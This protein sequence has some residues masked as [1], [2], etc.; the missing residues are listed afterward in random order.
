MKR[1]MMKC[2]GVA[3]CALAMGCS[4]AATASDGTTGDA[5][6][7]AEEASTACGAADW[8]DV[9]AV[10]VQS[11][12]SCH[13]PKPAAGAPMSLVTPADLKAA[14]L[15]MRGIDEAHYSVKRMAAGS[16]PP[17]G[18]AAGKV[19]AIQKWIDDG[20]PDPASCDAGK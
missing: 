19:A 8:A 17:G 1:L 9:D 4:D 11:C 13:G 16:M 12:Q 18:G 6:A 7:P 2:L 20:Y 10:L 5:G 3:C 14:S 15:T